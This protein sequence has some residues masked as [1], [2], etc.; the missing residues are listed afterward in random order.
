MSNLITLKKDDKVIEVT[1]R[2]FGIVYADQGFVKVEESK[3]QPLDIDLY[4]LTEEELKKI[5]KDDIKAFLDKENIE[6]EP[7]ANKDDLIKVVLGDDLD[8][9]PQ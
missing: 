1:E 3:K 6:Y 9:Q 7:K 2:A 8:G 4:E 5:N